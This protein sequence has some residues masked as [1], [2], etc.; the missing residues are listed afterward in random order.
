MQRND[1]QRM[2]GKDFITIGIFS[3]L[4]M[5]VF[6]IVSIPFTPFLAITYPFIGPVSAI[7][8][9][10]IFMLMTYKV[11]KRGTVL[12]CSTL[13]SLLY[14]LMGYVYLLPFGIVAGI[15]CEL[16]VWKKGAYR[17]FWNNTASFSIFSLWLFVGSSFIP[18]YVFGTE[19][20]QQLLSNNSASALV[21]IS[22]ATSPTWVIATVA[23]TIAGSIIGCLI[24]RK[25]LK[26]HFIKA[27]LVSAQ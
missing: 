11:A 13:I 14:V 5:V 17:S 10:S 27:G 16:P 1:S 24:G 3:V 7:F 21:H 25:L 9:A 15:L 20:Y 19:Q 18:V 8:T 23:M 6:T 26:K 4:L 2:K 12:L 22:F